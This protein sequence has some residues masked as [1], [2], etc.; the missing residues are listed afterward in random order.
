MGAL[1]VFAPLIT[2]LSKTAARGA[3]KAADPNESDLRRSMTMGPS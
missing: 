3:K 1:R 2:C